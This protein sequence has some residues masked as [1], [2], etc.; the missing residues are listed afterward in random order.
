MWDKI[1]FAFFGPPTDEGINKGYQV[2]QIEKFSK[3]RDK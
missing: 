2:N 1:T 3:L